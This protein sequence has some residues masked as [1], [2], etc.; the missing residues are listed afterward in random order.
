[1]VRITASDWSTIYRPERSWW[2]CQIGSPR[3]FHWAGRRSGPGSCYPWTRSR[4]LGS[5]WS[6]RRR[7]GCPWETSS[8]TDSPRQ[9]YK[10]FDDH[11]IELSS[12][13]SSGSANLHP[14][15]SNVSR[16]H[17]LH[18]LSSQRVL[19]EQLYCVVPSEPK[20]LLVLF[21]NVYM[22]TAVIGHSNKALSSDPSS[23][24]PTW[25]KSEYT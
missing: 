12:D 8:K 24:V 21:L 2:D 13:R 17:N 19:R 3:G 1:M 14:F 9:S 22:C 4:S 18:L 10:G 25:E 5:R 20:I 7:T 16:A 11:L 23:C 15:G 6:Q